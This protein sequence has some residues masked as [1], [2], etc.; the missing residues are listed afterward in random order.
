[1]ISDKETR[2][3]GWIV[4]MVYVYCTMN[5]L[6]IHTSFFYLD[7]TSKTTCVFPTSLINI[8]MSRFFFSSLKC[9]SFIMFTI[10]ILLVLP[11]MSDT[12]IFRSLNPA[13]K[14]QTFF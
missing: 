11:S 14:S 10:F 8:N 7:E 2:R 4:Q 6:I 5:N 9:F 3:V 13:I 1:M 12:F